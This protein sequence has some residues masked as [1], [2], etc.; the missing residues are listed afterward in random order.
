METIVKI[1]VTAICIFMVTVKIIGASESYGHL[2]LVDGMSASS[3]QDRVTF[4]VLVDTLFII[5][6]AYI[7][8][9]QIE[10]V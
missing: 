6:L 8:L 10:V 4:N 5:M 3:A 1:A 7:F 9:L 2:I